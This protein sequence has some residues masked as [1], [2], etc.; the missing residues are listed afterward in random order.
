V[1]HDGLPPPLRALL[2]RSE[3]KTL[4]ELLHST[5]RRDPSMRPTASAV[6]KELARLAPSL[7][8]TSWPVA[9]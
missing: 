9:P 1:G 6:R 5:L 3:L 8:Q 4:T 2:Q 7:A